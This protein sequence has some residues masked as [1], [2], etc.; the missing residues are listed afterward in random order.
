MLLFAAAPSSPR[1]MLR[2][3]DTCTLARKLKKTLTKMN[4][5]EEVAQ[6]TTQAKKTRARQ[7]SNS[8]CFSGEAVS[9]QFG[10]QS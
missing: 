4:C 10:S 2:R 9:N 7:E 6:A 8:V 5:A 3:S 1:Q